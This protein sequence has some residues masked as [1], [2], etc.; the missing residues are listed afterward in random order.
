MIIN[1]NES[2]IK[3]VIFLDFGRFNIDREKDDKK[4]E[5]WKKFVYDNPSVTKIE[6]CVSLT[7]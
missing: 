2:L 6:G 3:T 5:E 4:F 1:S 7:Q